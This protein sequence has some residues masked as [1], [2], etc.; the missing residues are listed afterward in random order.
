MPYILLA[1]TTLFWSSNFIVAKGF[2]AE[3]QP[4]TLAFL[5]W[6]TCLVIILP[7]VALRLWRLRATIRTHFIYLSGMGVI[8]ITLF[9]SLLYTGI[10]LSEV[11]NA[12]ILQSMTPVVILIICAFILKEPVKPS[13][14]L[15]VGVSFLGVLTIVSKASLSAILSLSF[16]KGD[17]LLLLA[18]LMW[19][20]YSVML[21]WLPK[22]IDGP[23]FFGFIV[24]IGAICLA[25]CA[26]IEV[27][28]HGKPDID[29]N[30]SLVI[31]YLAIFP[32]ILSGLFWNKGVKDLGPATCG[33]FIHLVPIYGF[34]LSFIFLNEHVKLY[35]LL[36]LV[37]VFTGV[38]FALPTNPFSKK[39][40]LQKTP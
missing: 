7:F 30:S 14:W 24:L 9:T 11:N 32:S 12:T 21:R 10:Q 16:S 37:L 35:H 34:I 19:A 31:L 26:F 38:F 3:V 2:S 28:I 29:V 36:G 33:L 17:I 18:M 15:G 27:K 39:R 20:I 1:L 23:S 13:Q 25:P 8:S 6:S 4:F 22:N 5:R 40:A